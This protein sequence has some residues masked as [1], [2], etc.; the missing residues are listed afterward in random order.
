M[1]SETEVISKSEFQVLEQPQRELTSEEAAQIQ[2]GF[3]PPRA[4]LVS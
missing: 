3:N 4:P 2:G 1:I